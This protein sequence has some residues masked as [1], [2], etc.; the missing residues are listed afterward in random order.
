VGG[1]PAF[2]QSMLEEFIA[3]AK[4]QIAAAISSHAEGSCK[5]VQ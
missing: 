3:E 2:V 4:E 5:G 1:D